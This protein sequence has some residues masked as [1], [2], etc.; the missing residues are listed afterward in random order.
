MHMNRRLWKS[1]CWIL[2]T[3][4]L[5]TVI[6]WAVVMPHPSSAATDNPPGNEPTS[7]NLP[8]H[9]VIFIS[10]VAIP[11]GP[12]VTKQQDSGPKKDQDLPQISAQGMQF[13][14]AVA[15]SS[16]L[17]A[18]QRILET[19]TVF[20]VDASTRTLAD[21]MKLKG[22]RLMIAGDTAFESESG[23]EGD[24][25]FD[26]IAVSL[27]RFELHDSPNRFQQFLAHEVQHDHRP[28]CLIV[29]DRNAKTAASNKAPS[30]S[31]LN[32]AFIA[33]REALPTDS[34]I[35]MYTA[36]CGESAKA[37]SDACDHCLLDVP[38]TVVWDRHIPA[39]RTSDALIS[40]VDIL[41]TLVELIGATP[42][43]EIDGRSFASV[44]RGE[45]HEHR[46]VAFSII[47]SGKENERYCV[48]DSRFIY[49]SAKSFHTDAVALYDLLSDPRAESDLK[50]DPGYR[51]HVLEMRDQ[52]NLWLQRHGRPS[53]AT[54][55]SK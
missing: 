45:S 38:L 10:D 17:A 12:A 47:D 30:T 5:L 44:L 55:N 16:E 18:G 33:V 29:R 22:Y 52:L 4:S 53:L 13:N 2:L 39:G 50:A 20:S 41:P 36:I 3:V 27:E 37:T 31:S 9:V 54:E 51:Q 7:S 15:S 26:V 25:R 14:R 11:D 35:F 32:H 34:T 49:L 43:S 23:Q 48:Q 19:G 6:A 21:H 40:T 1:R 28:L 24:F 42:P 8:P 46:D